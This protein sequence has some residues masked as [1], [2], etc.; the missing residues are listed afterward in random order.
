MSVDWLPVLLVVQHVL[1]T[2]LTRHLLQYICFASNGTLFRID[3]LQLN[4]IALSKSGA[5]VNL[6]FCLQLRSECKFVCSLA[7]SFDYE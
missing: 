4:G 1:R 7:V 2:M 5:L 6:R 3:R